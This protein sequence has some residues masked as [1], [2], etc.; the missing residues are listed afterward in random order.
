MPRGSLLSKSMPSAS[1]V[2]CACQGGHVRAIKAVKMRKCRRNAAGVSRVTILGVGVFS[3]NYACTLTWPHTVFIAVPV[4]RWNFWD[5]KVAHRSA[6]TRA[7]AA[8]PKEF[9]SIGSPAAVVRRQRRTVSLRALR[10]HQHSGALP[11]GLRPH[12]ER[13]RHAYM[14]N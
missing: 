4:D 2:P 11:A 7:Y 13:C 3:S 10:R 12:V 6:A 8:K 9:P 14:Q 1:M 5:C